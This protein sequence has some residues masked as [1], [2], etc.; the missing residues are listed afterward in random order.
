M[1][2]LLLA[3]FRLEEEEI[4]L[5]LNGMRTTYTAAAHISPMPVRKADGTT[6]TDEPALFGFFPGEPVSMYTEQWRRRTRDELGY[7]NSVLFGY[8]MDHEGYLLIPE[9]WLAGGYEPDISFQGPLSGEYLM[10]QVMAYTGR[11][12]GSN[13]DEPFNESRGAWDYPEV[14][15]P[16]IQPDTTPT[17]GTKLSNDTL[18]EYLWIPDDFT[19]DLDIP[20]E[21]P[22]ITGMVQVAWEGGDPGV[23]NPRVT[24]QRQDESGAWQDVTSHS[25]RVINE[26]HHDFAL[27]HTPDPLFPAEA[28]QTHRWWTVWQAVG[29]VRDRAGVPEGTY[30]LHIEGKRY[31]GEDTTWPWSTEP[32]TLSSDPFEVVPAEIDLALGDGFVT[33]SLQG[34]EDGYRLVDIDGYS[35]GANPLRGDLEVVWLT[36][37]DSITETVAAPAPTDQRTVLSFPPDATVLG[38]TITDAY[39]NTGSIQLD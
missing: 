27:G 19:L 15:L 38:V 9:D 25:G 8:A 22:R 28:V 39:G 16:T 17:A 21:V 13:T 12:L 4:A 14:P 37:Q 29:H 2:R 10:E 3:F 5:P 11:I 23:D 1:S 6:S 32:Y 26:D 24:L 7:D 35:R 34:P 31:L 20:A 33:A 18:P 36:A 30:R